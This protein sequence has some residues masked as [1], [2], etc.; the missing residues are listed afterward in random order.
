M[1]KPRL[2]DLT[3][4]STEELERD[5]LGCADDIALCKGALAINV[6]SYHGKSVGKRLSRNILLHQE[7]EKELARRT[8]EKARKL[9]AQAG[10]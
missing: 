10:D 7:L 3:Q 6:T 8:K 5:L 9:L 1:E 2:V 4:F